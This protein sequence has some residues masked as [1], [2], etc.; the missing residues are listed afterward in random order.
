M[1]RTLK[2]ES[3]SARNCRA[4]ADGGRRCVVVG[5]TEHPTSLP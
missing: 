3:K 2:R 4:G 5:G 1:K